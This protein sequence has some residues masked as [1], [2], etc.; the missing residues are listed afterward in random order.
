VNPYANSVIAEYEA[1]AFIQSR[2]ESAQA[3]RYGGPSLTLALV[4]II[5]RRFRAFADRIERWAAAPADRDIAAPQR[6]VAVR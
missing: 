2:R 4:A 6:P 5:A 3:I 1:R